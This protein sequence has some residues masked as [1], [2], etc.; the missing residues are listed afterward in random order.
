MRTL[1]HVGF[2]LVELLIVIAIIG[3]FL[4]L[5]LPAVQSAREASRRSSLRNQYLQEFGPEAE[6]E[7][8]QPAAV[9]YPSARVLS[10]TADITLTPMLSVGTATPE[11]IYSAQFD[12]S[13]EVTHPAGQSGD[14][15]VVLPLPP[16]VISLAGLEISSTGLPSEQVKIRHGKLVWRGEL[17]AESV[18][19]DVT[20]TA[21][22]R[23][24][25]Q[26]ALNTGGLLDKY[27]VS[28]TTKG[29]D[30]RLLELSLQPTTI[31]H[32]AGSSTYRWDYEQLLFGRPLH[33]DVLGIAPIDRLGELTWLG[34][35]SVVVFGLLVGLVVQAVSVPKFDRWILLLTIGTFAGAYP[36]MYF[37]QEY[38]ALLPAMLISGGIAVAIIG[39][40]TTTLMGLREAL[41]GILIPAIVIMAI[42]LSA[43]IWP[44]LQGLLLTVLALSLFVVAMTL[45]P[46]IAERGSDFWGLLSRPP[47]PA[48]QPSA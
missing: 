40:R 30:V 24:L 37:A 44:Q 29:S 13:L 15:E 35:L 2:T 18:R 11:S 8:G 16:Q 22:G 48:G 4:S 31:E 6:F 14:C 47:A 32:L 42:C 12:G 7:D 27:Q 9:I 21:V 17:P 45:M 19:L 26:M 1:R 39:I 3:T 33:V 23:G 41:L 34:P 43:V 36:L 20:Y 10:Y 25:Y 28:L 38:V 46:K 5:L